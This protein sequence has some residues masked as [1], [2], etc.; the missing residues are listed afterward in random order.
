M[1]KSYN[2]F[3]E[4]K[5]NIAD[6]D[7]G[8]LT[9]GSTLINNDQQSA[10]F[11]QKNTKGVLYSQRQLINKIIYIENSEYES[12]KY[13]SEGQRKTYINISRF[14][15]DVARMRTDIDVK[16]YIF[17]PDS[18]DY[19]WEAYFMQRQFKVFSRV[20]N[21]GEELNRLGDDYCTYGTAVSKKV[22]KNVV[23]VPIRSLR[24]T[25][26]A[27]TLNHAAKTGGYVIEEHKYTKT[28]MESF[29]DWDV[30][31]LE[32]GKEYTVYERYSLVPQWV[33]D[34]YN[35]K[36][37]SDD[38]MV[39]CVQILLPEEDGK[40]DDGGILYMEKIS[41]TPYEEVRWEIVDGRWLGRGPIEI[42]FENQIARNM[43]ANLRRR[44]LLWGSKKI[45]QSQ[46]DQIQKNLI[47][48]VKDGQVLEV[49]PNG[50]ISQVA[51]ESR[52]L[53]EYTSDEAMIDKNIQ[54][55]SFTFE[56]ATG[57][58][59]PS[60]TPFRLG[61]LLNQA[62]ETFY[63]LKR[64]QFGLWA[65]RAF[66][67]QMIPV[68]KKQVKDHTV[69]IGAGESG[70]D[71]LKETM[72]EMHVRERL[73]NLAHTGLTPD[74]A[75]E[76]VTKEID[77]RPALFI[78]VPK[79]FYDEA[80]LHMDLDITGEAEDTQEVI[81]TLTTLYQSMVQAQDP[82]AETVLETILSKS[83]KNLQ[84]IA[85]KKQPISQQTMLQGVQMPQQ[86]AQTQ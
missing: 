83:G 66:F 11:L 42:Q 56:V 57:E 19:F 1:L 65:K 13:D 49:G 3:A 5:K 68:F 18:H 29:P 53:Q 10:R 46:S 25:Q 70:F 41:D 20:N 59:M 69:L 32:Y 86:N 6:F 17:N 77:S 50:Q 84:A 12:G 36:E 81:Q 45:F 23:R 52:N 85:G 35:G 55:T 14:V 38:K 22:G 39:L 43:T 51:M 44:A 33:Y 48:D 26:D 80:I 8:I 16:N 31:N 75:R 61:V 34:K 72:I 74:K 71:I 60:G 79:G 58:S 73:I 30:S 67:S 15:R 9:L 2:I 64:E 78:K 21:Y 76:M 4:L 24:N 37:S 62:V 40:R 27:K 28:E 63:T 47:R 54:Q 7:Q 82:R